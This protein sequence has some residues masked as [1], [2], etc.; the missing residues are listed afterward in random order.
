MTIKQNEILEKAKKIITERKIGANRIETCLTADICPNCGE[1]G[2][3][4]R[5]KKANDTY[6]IYNFRCNQCLALYQKLAHRNEEWTE[7][8]P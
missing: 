3:P 7:T 5:R 6:E 1:P 4:K 2:E 8:L